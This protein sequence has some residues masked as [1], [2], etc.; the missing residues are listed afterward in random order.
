MAANFG[1]LFDIDGVFVRGKQ[2]L[3]AAREA[4]K[5]LTDKAG[6][7]RVPAVFL[8]NAGNKLPTTKAVELSDI[9]GVNVC[10]C[11]KFSVLVSC[12]YPI[13][14]VTLCLYQICRSPHFIV[15]RSFAR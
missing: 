13:S 5:L 14:L 8:T 10:Q 6:R 3:P 11:L 15:L 7:F 2:V 4:V 9:L 1:F 12:T